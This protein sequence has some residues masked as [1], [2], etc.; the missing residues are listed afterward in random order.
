MAEPLPPITPAQVVTLR[1]LAITLTKV[2]LTVVAIGIVAAV[3]ALCRA[4]FGTAAGLV[5]WIPFAGRIVSS[6]IHAIERKVSNFLGGLEEHI[7]AN[8]GWYF[9][10]WA[11]LIGQLGDGTAEAGWVDWLLGRTIGLTRKAVNALPSRGSVTQTTTRIVKVTKVIVQRVEHIG[12]IAAHAA[13]G[14]TLANL[15]AVAGA[16]DHVIEWDLPSLRARTKAIEQRLGRLADRLK[17]GAKPLVGL[18]ATALVV[19]VLRRIGLNWLRCSNVKK[20]GRRICGLDPSTIE[21]LLADTL[22]IVGTVS[23]LEFIR[24]AQAVEG[25]ALDALGLF[26]REMPRA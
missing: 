2:S 20:V 3:D 15:R 9:H 22:A 12:K 4:F 16:L 1:A 11:T 21:G 8:M 14:V 13:P 23:L 26:I 7:D 5:G 24:D 18:A 25:A 17:G 10:T 19:G 6:P